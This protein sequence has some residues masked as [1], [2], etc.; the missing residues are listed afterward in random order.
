MRG[1]STLSGNG[2]VNI[3]HFLGTTI[4][5]RLPLF[6]NQVEVDYSA[7]PLQCLTMLTFN[8]KS[9]RSMFTDAYSLSNCSSTPSW[10][11]AKWAVFEYKMCHRNIL[12]GTNG[13]IFSGQ[14]VHDNTFHIITDRELLGHCCYICG[15][16]TQNL[17][18]WPVV[19]F[20]PKNTLL[21]MRAYY[22]YTALI[23]VHCAII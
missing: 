13:I 4:L 3:S 19:R 7:G 10:G 14:S 1:L 8:G 9:N 20:L 17:P 18:I 22:L 12:N 5:M 6:P 15:L 21:D 23:H 2:V 16:G 11:Q